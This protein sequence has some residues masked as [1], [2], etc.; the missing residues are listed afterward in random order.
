MVLAHRVLGLQ[1]LGDP[2]GHVGGVVLAVALPRLVHSDSPPL[3]VHVADPQG[4]QLT[5]P[6]A[7]P[8]G[9]GQQS[10]SGTGEAYGGLQLPLGQEPQLRT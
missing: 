5:E 9:H 2:A 8:H 1:L 10:A 6:Q 3:Q 4:R 7:R